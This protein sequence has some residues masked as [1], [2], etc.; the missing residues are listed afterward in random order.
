M[1]S[2]LNIVAISRDVGQVNVALDCLLIPTEHGGD[3][4]GE[5]GMTNFVDATCVHPMLARWLMA[6][7]TV[8]FGTT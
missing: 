8:V 7:E 1:L 6:S 5:L 4:F 3:R 2:M